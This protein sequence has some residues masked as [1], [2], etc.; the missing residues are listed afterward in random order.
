MLI[1]HGQLATW[2]D[3]LRFWFIDSQILAMIVL[4]DI[5]VHKSMLFVHSF[6][7]GVITVYT[8]PKC[9]VVCY[10]FQSRNWCMFNYMFRLSMHK[11]PMLRNLCISRNNIYNLVAVWCIWGIIRTTLSRI[12]KRVYFLSICWKGNTGFLLCCGESL[13]GDSQ[14]A[15][16]IL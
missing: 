8:C 10:C 15:S 5:H 4:S 13:F 9:S 1:R 16:A 14:F 7:F 11:K 12:A 6:P 3:T 2:A